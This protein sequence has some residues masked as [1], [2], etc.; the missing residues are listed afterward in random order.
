MS[1]SDPA[2]ILHQWLSPAFPVGGFSYSHGMEMAVAAGDV[3]NAA[4]AE[5]WIATA[6]EYGAGQS[7][8]ILLA[9][10][11]RAAPGELPDLIAL[12]RALSPSSERLQEADRMGTA[13]ATTTR[14]L[15][16]IDVPDAPYPVAFGSAARTMNLPLDLTLRLFVQAFAANLVSAAV[17]LVPLGQTAGQK[18]TFALA[19]LIA[20][21][22]ERAEPGDTDQIGSAA[23]KIDLAS[24]Q[25]ETLTTR[26]FQS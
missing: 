13:F 2:L 10:T 8:A 6:L 24:M 23:L 16:D 7:D 4:T 21:V 22:A 9:A 20:A 18:I 3:T 15:H 12:S 5:S 14:A 19:P 1:L 11:Y 17:R 25:H 26:L